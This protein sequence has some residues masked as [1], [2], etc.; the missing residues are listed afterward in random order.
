MRETLAT[1]LA[2]QQQQYQTFVWTT[3]TQDRRKNTANEVNV[4]D[5]KVAPVEEVDFVILSGKIRYE[6]KQKTVREILP[7][8]ERTVKRLQMI[9]KT[10]KKFRYYM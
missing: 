10:S 2:Q 4:N 7:L 3:K 9:R 1:L 5:W 6:I 8:E